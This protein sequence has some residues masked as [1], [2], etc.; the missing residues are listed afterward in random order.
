MNPLESPTIKEPTK[1]DIE[2]NFQVYKESANYYMMNSKQLL[3]AIIKK[4]PRGL[5]IDVLKEEGVVERDWNAKGNR[6]K[7]KEVKKK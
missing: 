1:T 3:R 4:A 7:L 6:H 2:L 5:L